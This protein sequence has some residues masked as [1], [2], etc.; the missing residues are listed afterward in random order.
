M[1]TARDRFSVAVSPAE[2]EQR[3]SRLIDPRE[4][5]QALRNEYGLEDTRGWSLSRARV[6]LRDRPDWKE[7]IRSI[8]HAPFD[9]RYV[10]YDIRLI[11]SSPGVAG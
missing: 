1:I 2:L 10:A 7:S 5:D 3:V 6:A 8:L 11:G 9:C 4:T